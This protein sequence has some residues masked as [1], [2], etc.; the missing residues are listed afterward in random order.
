MFCEP[1]FSNILIFVILKCIKKNHIRKKKY[2]IF[3]LDLLIL[4]KKIHKI[5]SHSTMNKSQTSKEICCFCNKSSRFQVLLESCDHSLCTDCLEII[6]L[7][8]SEKYFPFQIA[9]L[10]Q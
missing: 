9:P 4:K 2:S 6:Q 7:I 10:S 3:A 5:N 8:D 1:I